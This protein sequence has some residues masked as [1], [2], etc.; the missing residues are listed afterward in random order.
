MVFAGRTSSTKT[1]PSSPRLN[2]LPA[3]WPSPTLT[4][5]AWLPNAVARR[6][7]RVPT[8]APEA[9]TVEFSFEGVLA[10]EPVLRDACDIDPR[11]PARALCAGRPRRLG[12][13]LRDDPRP[14]DCGPQRPASPHRYQGCGHRPFG[15]LDS[16]LALLVTVRAFDA[17]GLPRRYHGGFHARFWHDAP[18]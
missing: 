2:C 18:H 8:D 1:A 14:T 5:T 4:L 9:T 17:L 12:R 6:R 13:A 7:G 16:T 15:R 11:F 10:E 3:T